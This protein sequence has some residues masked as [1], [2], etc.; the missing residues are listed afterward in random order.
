[1]FNFILMMF[2]IFLVPPLT[3]IFIFLISLFYQYFILVKIKKM[4]RKKRQIE[5][6]KKVG[7]F[8]KI[9]YVFPKQLAL[10]IVK[11]DPEDFNEWGVHLICGE[12]GSGK[13]ITT[14][15]LLQ[16]W[17][18]KYP[19]AKIT[20]NMTYKYEDRPLLHWKDL[21]NYQ[22]GKYGT[23]KVLDEIQTWFNSN[24]SKDFPVEML[25]EVS[26]QRKQRSAIIGTTQV[27]NRVAKPLR[28][29]THFV[30]LP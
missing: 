6:E 19:L 9:F 5:R 20:T 26:Q 22:N 4:K 12:Q 8:K 15:Y 11:K 28:E 25:G 16:E 14:C 23:I 29:Q 7:F 24:Q 21:L 30:Y 10:D 1:M 3:I 2:L 13:T 18:R 17:K 27:F